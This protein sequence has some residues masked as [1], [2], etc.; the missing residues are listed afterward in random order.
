MCQHLG[1]CLAIESPQWLPAV[2]LTVIIITPLPPPLFPS[3][4]SFSSSIFTTITIIT[5]R[6]FLVPPCWTHFF[7]FLPPQI[8]KSYSIFHKN[9]HLI[10]FLLHMNF[11]QLHIESTA[12]VAFLEK[13]PPWFCIIPHGTCLACAHTHTS[14]HSHTQCLLIT[15]IYF[16]LNTKH[17]LIIFLVELLCSPKSKAKSQIDG[18]GCTSEGLPI[19]AAN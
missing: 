4:S 11:L 6:H 15:W 5:H 12:V 3:S 7:F 19:I 9:I 16:L 14:A 8:W 18:F 13:C 17:L 10:C 1:W 2:I